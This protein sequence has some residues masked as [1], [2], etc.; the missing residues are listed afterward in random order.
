MQVLLFSVGM[1]FLVFTGN[2]DDIARS[3]DM[4]CRDHIIQYTPCSL[5]SVLGNI[6]QG[7]VFLDRRV[8][9]VPWAILTQL[10]NSVKHT[11]SDGNRFDAKK[12]RPLV[13]EHK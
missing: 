13:G 9:G 2:R 6:A 1:Y 5:G 8:C 11:K 7:T 12:R 10:Y 4:I 3:H